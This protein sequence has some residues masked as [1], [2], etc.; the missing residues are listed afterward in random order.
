VIS[1]PLGQVKPTG[2]TLIGDR[3]YRI[4]FPA[5]TENGIYHFHLSPTLRDAE[6]YQLDQNANGI[7]GSSM[8][9]SPGAERR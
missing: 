4:T 8:T 5:L 7:P 9:V 3:T 1:G 6:G 2:F